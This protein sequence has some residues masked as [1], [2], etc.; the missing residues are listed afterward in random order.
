MRFW[1]FRPTCPYCGSPDIFR[2]RRRSF[3][4][5]C[6]TLLSL[7][8]YRCIRCDRRHFGYRRIHEHRIALPPFPKP[9]K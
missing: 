2:S 4:E 1:R 7:R 8:P 6:L 5:Y 3:G 9:A